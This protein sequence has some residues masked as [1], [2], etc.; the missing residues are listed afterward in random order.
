MSSFSLSPFIV[1]LRELA[2]N[3]GL[4][5]KALKQN[6][7]VVV[8]QSRENS[9]FILLPPALY[10]SLFELYRDL[11][12]ADDLTQAM[13]HEEKFHDFEDIEQEFLSD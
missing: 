9:F 13:I 6:K 4:R 5:R 10:N 8:E 1:S 11:R 3:A 2:R 12:D 7:P